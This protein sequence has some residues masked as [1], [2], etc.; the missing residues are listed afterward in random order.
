[1]GTLVLTR[2]KFSYEKG[3]TEGGHDTVAMW[4]N[5]SINADDI[6]KGMG[7]L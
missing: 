6:S 5:I 3:T 7:T 2:Q 1:M 4:E